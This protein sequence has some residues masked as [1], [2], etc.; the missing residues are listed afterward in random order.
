MV[1]RIIASATFVSANVVGVSRL[2]NH[3]LTVSNKLLRRH[4][5][6]QSRTHVHSD[7]QSGTCSRAQI[8]RMTTVTPETNSV[9]VQQFIRDATELGTIRFICVSRGGAVLETIGRF[10]Y[11]LKTTNIPSKGEYI[12]IASEDKTFECHIPTANVHHITLS[13]DKAKLGDYDLHAIRLFSADETIVLSC[14]LQF[15]PSRGPGNYLF[16][17]VDAFNAL[18]S[19]YGSQVDII[20]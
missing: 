12:S 14:V 13:T 2:S 18:R 3:L 7:E 17:A 6:A 5:C 16:G 10:D 19:R 11:T 1:A 15:D 9:S 20:H 8:V 4:T